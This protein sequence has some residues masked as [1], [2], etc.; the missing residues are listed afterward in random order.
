LQLFA[1]PSL[2]LPLELHALQIRFEAMIPKLPNSW[3]ILH[4]SE[5]ATALF[6]KGEIPLAP[7]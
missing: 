5:K 3:I 6:C 4:H 2:A 7:L 1:D